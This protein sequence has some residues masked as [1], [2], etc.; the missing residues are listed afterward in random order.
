[1]VT[2]HFVKILE[3]SNV[4]VI[5]I[6]IIDDKTKRA[7]QSCYTFGTKVFTVRKAI[8]IPTSRSGVIFNDMNNII[9]RAYET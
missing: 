5:G 4:F 1:M 8:Y 9:G 6:I 2:C 3:M 7:Q